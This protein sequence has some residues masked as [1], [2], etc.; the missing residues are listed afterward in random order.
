MG[1]PLRRIFSSGF[2]T[3]YQLECHFTRVLGRDETLVRDW[4]LWSLFVVSACLGNPLLLC[5]FHYE[6]SAEK[7]SSFR[8]Q[9]IFEGC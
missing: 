5:A 1:L 3:D 9:L 6:R 4:S 2:M 7:N 8:V